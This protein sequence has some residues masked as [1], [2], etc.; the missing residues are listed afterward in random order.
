M[1]LQHVWNVHMSKYAA[2]TWL[3]TRQLCTSCKGP[4]VLSAISLLHINVSSTLDCFG[5][6]L[7]KSFAWSKSSSSS[8]AFASQKAHHTSVPNALVAEPT[9]LNEF[10]RTCLYRS[11]CG[12][13]FGICTS[14][15]TIGKWP[16]QGWGL[17]TAKVSAQNVPTRLRQTHPLFLSEQR[18]DSWGPGESRATSGFKLTECK[19]L[20]ISG[21]VMWGHKTKQRC[22]FSLIDSHAAWLV[23]VGDC[24][25]K[26][27]ALCTIPFGFLSSHRLKS[28]F[29]GSVACLGN[30][31]DYLDFSW[32]LL[33]QWK[34][35]WHL[36]SLFRSHLGF[37]INSR[38]GSYL[39][40]RFDCEIWSCL[41]CAPAISSSSS[42]S[43]NWRRRSCCIKKHR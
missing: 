43:R 9:R 35:V 30:Q 17:F 14:P 5:N 13:W 8:N 32:A 12:H 42:A 34:S 6:Y 7:R 38:D 3:I 11:C 41:S 15:A 19:H 16:L 10:N 31:I 1:C 2:E 22:S 25:M 39:W 4:S 23:I 27:S 26:A 20:C 40:Q 29:A 24:N 21:V 28:F 37:G 33:V 36:L 18:V